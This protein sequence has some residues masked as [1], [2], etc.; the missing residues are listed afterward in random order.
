MFAYQAMGPWKWNGACQCQATGPLTFFL[1]LET[2]EHKKT[3]EQNN[4]AWSYISGR[5]VESIGQIN[6]SFKYFSSLLLVPMN[7][8]ITF[9]VQT[10]LQVR[11]KTTLTNSCPYLFTQRLGY[12]SS[13]RCAHLSS[14]SAGFSYTEV[15]DNQLLL[16]ELYTSTPWPRKAGKK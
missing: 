8:T 12:P 5:I 2:I 16:G 11:S 6:G 14:G 15:L 13:E 4:T 9:H 10:F 3:W 7:Y 1:N